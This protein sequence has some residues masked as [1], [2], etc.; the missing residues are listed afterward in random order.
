MHLV[1]GIEE[2]QNRLVRVLDDLRLYAT[3]QDCR[4]A[5]GRPGRGLPADLARP[6]HSGLGRPAELH[7]MDMPAGCP[8]QADPAPVRLTAEPTV[9]NSSWP[10]R[11][12]RPRSKSLAATIQLDG[13]PAMALTSAVPGMHGRPTTE[14]QLFEPFA[15][16]TREAMVWSC[17]SPDDWSSCMGAACG[18]AP[19]RRAKPS[20]C[21]NS[22]TLKPAA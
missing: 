10:W 7:E 14:N 3:P 21:W 17:R 16:G 6:G 20:W 15:V 1:Q 12:R 9:W 4:F 5:I 8:C 2:G 18:Q 11:A 19:P 13:K 22:A